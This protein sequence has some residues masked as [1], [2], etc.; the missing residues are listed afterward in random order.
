MV[1]VG[2]VV[3]DPILE[4]PVAEGEFSPMTHRK[5]ICIGSSPDNLQT[6]QEVL[7]SPAVTVIGAHELDLSLG[8]VS[9]TDLDI[10][11]IDAG[12]TSS[13]DV[14]LCQRLRAMFDGAIL[15]IAPTAA[16]D[17]HVAAYQAGVN[18]SIDSRIGADLMRAKI[19]VWLR[20]TQQQTVAQEQSADRPQFQHS[21]RK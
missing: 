12:H 17:F 14:D 7:R 6:W 21:P 1:C 4:S 19:D 11:L 20:V 3:E 18:E 8:E 16:E 10:L 2:P 15:M 9:P 13:V 5:I